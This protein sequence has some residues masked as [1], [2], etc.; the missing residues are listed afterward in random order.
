MSETL[1]NLVK[2]FIGESQA[3]NRY[4]FYAK[5]AKREGYEQIA[6]IFL[7]T[8]ENEK[9]HASTLFK[10]IDELRRKGDERIEDV[11]VEVTAP[12]TIGNTIENLKAA[13]AGENHEHTQMYPEFAEVAEREGLSRIAARLRAIAKAEKH[14]EERYRKLLKEVEAGTFFKKDREVWWVCMECGY[15]HY[16]R[17]PPER[18]PSCNHPRSYFK[19]KREEY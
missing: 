3:R 10:F 18:C 13:I 12:I 9:E 2:A 6:E 16:G 19:I 7:E 4:T 15:I 17:E 11:K 8:A 14:H 5:I 1:K